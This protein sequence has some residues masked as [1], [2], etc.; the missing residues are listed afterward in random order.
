MADYLR[1]PPP[2]TVERDNRDAAARRRREAYR[3]RKP[4]QCGS[5]G[6]ADPVRHTC[7]ACDPLTVAIWKKW[8][9]SQ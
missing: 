5:G 8:K 6:L 9:A 3:N 1:K 4:C 7:I 2:H